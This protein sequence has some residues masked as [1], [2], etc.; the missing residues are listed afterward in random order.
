MII[1]LNKY[2]KL[3]IRSTD[4]GIKVTM[5]EFYSTCGWR[6]L[7]AELF[8]DVETIEWYYGIEL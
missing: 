7:S 5:F 4:K 1:K 2:H 6:K 3:D 8:K